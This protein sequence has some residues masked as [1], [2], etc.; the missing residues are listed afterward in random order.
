MTNITSLPK[1]K[2]KLQ[3]REYLGILR[4]MTGQQRVLLGCELYDLAIRLMQDGIRH[5][6]PEYDD[7]QV[8]QE[9]KKRMLRC[10]R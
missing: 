9:T 2:D 7:R 4:K 6:H 3:R 1:L 8:Q 10:N 5:R